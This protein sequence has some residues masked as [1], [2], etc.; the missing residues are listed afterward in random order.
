MSEW[1]TYRAE[2]FLLFSPRVYWR[3]FELHNAALWPLHVLTLAAGLITWQV[4]RA[5][6]VTE[7][8]REVGIACLVGLLV[9]SISPAWRPLGMPL[10]SYAVFALLLEPLGLMISI[11]ALCVVA[12]FADRD[13]RPLGVAGM[14]LF[15]CVLC[16]LCG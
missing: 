1:W 7:S 15:L 3:M 11:A 6:G 4:M 12:A 5:I 8:Y 10:A 13:H 14:T 16:A 2:D 9:I